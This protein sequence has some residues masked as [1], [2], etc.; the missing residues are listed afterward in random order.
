MIF[1]KLSVR[2]VR[3]S[4]QQETDSPTVIN[5]HQSLTSFSRPIKIIIII[6]RNRHLFI[7][8]S[9]GRDWDVS[10]TG[11]GTNSCGV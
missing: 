2:K 5:H 6:I 10:I 8:S 1:A 3:D 4:K 7:S 9:D 11:L